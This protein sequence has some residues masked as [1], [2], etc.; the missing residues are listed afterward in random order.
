MWTNDPYQLLPQ[1]NRTV[2]RSHFLLE[3]GEIEFTSSIALEK[4]L[5]LVSFDFQ[6]DHRMLVFEPRKPRCKIAPEKIERYS[7]TDKA[8]QQIVGHRGV[9]L[10]IKLQ[11]L[12][13]VLQE[14]VAVRGQLDNATLASRQ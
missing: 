1:G 7:E 9:G 11:N 13:R 4:I 6:P 8:R 10:V 3:E 12:S 5:R 2:L 14:F